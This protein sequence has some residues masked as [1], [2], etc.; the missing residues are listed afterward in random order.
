MPKTFEQIARELH[1]PEYDVR[2]LYGRA[3][4]KLRKQ[5][6]PEL[7]RECLQLLA[8]LEERSFA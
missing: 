8:E 6:P 2:A 1:I 5:M 7:K 4:K 3:F